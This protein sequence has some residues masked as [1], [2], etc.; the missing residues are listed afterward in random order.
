MSFLDWLRGRP[1]PGAPSEP[2]GAG[3]EQLGWR[4][5]LQ[6]AAEGTI[7]AARVAPPAVVVRAHMDAPR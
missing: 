3:F 4:V 5:D 6:R 7:V 1:W 2:T